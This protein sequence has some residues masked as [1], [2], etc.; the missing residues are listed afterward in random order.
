[1]PTIQLFIR[2]WRE[3]S[4][5]PN[6]PSVFHRYVN[7]EQTCLKFELWSPY[8]F[9]TT[10]RI[11]LHIYIYIYHEVT[12]SLVCSLTLSL[13]LSIYI[14]I[15]ISCIIHPS[16]PSFL[17]QSRP[18]V[19]SLHS[20]EIH[21]YLVI[22]QNLSVY[23]GSAWEDVTSKSVLAFQQCVVGLDHLILTVYVIPW[24]V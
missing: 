13:S 19:Q 15:Y 10:T 8:P 12:L 2:T 24:F 18:H 14:Y 9:P 16:H 3:T 11:T 1:M 23:S 7:C 6:F 17:L 4:S 22:V 5:F 21:T 20:A